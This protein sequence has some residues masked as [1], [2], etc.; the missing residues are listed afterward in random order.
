MKDCPKPWVAQIRVGGTVRCL[1]TYATELEAAVAYDQAARIM[2][3]EFA[4]L[5]FPDA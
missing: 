1:G 3:D 5:N 4:N 2:R